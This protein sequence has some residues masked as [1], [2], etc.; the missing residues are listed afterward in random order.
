MRCPEC[1]KFVALNLE[2]PNVEV[3]YDATNPTDAVEGEIITSDVEVTG[4][5]SLALN[6]A[7]CSTT[8][9]TAELEIGPETVTVDHAADCT[10]QEDFDLTANFE[11]FDEFLP[12]GRKR[13]WHFYGVEGNVVVS[14]SCCGASGT[15]E[16]KVS[17]KSS[18]MDVAV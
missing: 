14:C 7:D 5:A 1:R 6:C 11:N 15:F 9:K 17:I 10:E 16:A 4:T 3:D 8:L 12:P 2:E 13:Q 18:E